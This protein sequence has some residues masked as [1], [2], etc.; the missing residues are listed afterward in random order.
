MLI[1]LKKE[2]VLEH[3]LWDGF[4]EMLCEKLGINFDDVQSIDCTKVNV[5]PDVQELWFEAA[6][7]ADIP[8]FEL[9]QMILV[10]GPKAVEEGALV[11]SAP[12]DAFEVKEA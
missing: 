3:P 12:A 7:A 8:E 6:K 4:Y 5:S 11:V 2:E 10:Y 1:N 9:S